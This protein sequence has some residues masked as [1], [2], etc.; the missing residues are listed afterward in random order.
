[1]HHLIVVV[2]VVL[3]VVFYSRALFVH[4]QN[5]FF[6]DWLPILHS[7]NMACS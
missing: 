2:V 6:K 7:N 3:A 4:T 1:M 5:I